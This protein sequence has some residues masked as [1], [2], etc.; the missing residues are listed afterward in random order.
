MEGRP[1]SDFDDELDAALK[2]GSKPSADSG[3]DDE[4]NGA[5]KP[6]PKPEEGGLMS[7]LRTVLGS[8]GS[9]KT[10]QQQQDDVSNYWTQHY[11]DG[12]GNADT[13]AMAKAMGG[14]ALESAGALGSMGIAPA[15]AAGKGLMSG[16]AAVGKD[17]LGQ[18]AM[19]AIQGAGDAIANG[20]DMQGMLKRVLASGGISGVAELGMSAMGGMAGKTGDLF[21]MLGRKADNT[22]AG[23]TSKIR[24]DLIEKFGIENGP[25]KLGELVRKYSPSSLFSPKTSA[26][27]LSAI[28]SQ[29]GNEGSNLAAMTRQAGEEGADA[30]APA[31]MQG[32]HQDMLGKA[33]GLDQVARSDSKASEAKML[34]AI[35]NRSSSKPDP[36]T[37]EGLIGAKAQFGDDAFRKVTGFADEDAKSQAAKQAWM[38]MKDAEQNALQSATPDTAA[39]F[40]DSQKTFGQLSSLHDSLKPRASADDAVGNAGSAMLSAG[41]GAM[42]P[43]GQGL[44]GALTSGTNNAVRQMTGGV[45][46]DMFANVMHPAGDAMRGLGQGLDRVP[47][48]ALAAEGVDQQADSDKTK[49]YKDLDLIKEALKQNPRILGSYGPRLQQSQDL[50]GDYSR[51]MDDD[52][53][54]QRMMKNVHATMAGMQR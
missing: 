15:K 2:G 16:L 33:A 12:Q 31:A 21:S 52:P 47:T 48:G 35:L 32:A 49:G 51:L 22:K 54:F 7:M 39:R 24:D 28:E 26:G 14:Q 42:L 36:S 40:G 5:L 27:H 38:T 46:H 3:F 34:E 50:S 4:L 37:F 41:V 53:Q 11:S 45:A 10:P 29:L 19:G 13:G 30:A 9:D 43:G 1:V 25:D 20:E 44:M 18:G 6:K 17:G 23:S 8:I